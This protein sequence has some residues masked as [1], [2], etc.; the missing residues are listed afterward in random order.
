MYGRSNVHG[1]PFSV[2]AEKPQSSD[3]IAEMLRTTLQ[4]AE[5]AVVVNEIVSSRHAVLD[6]VPRGSFKICWLRM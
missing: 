1:S 3:E 6:A 4:N 5:P 2:L